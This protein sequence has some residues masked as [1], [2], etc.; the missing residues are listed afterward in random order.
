MNGFYDKIILAV[1]VLALAGSAGYY[2][3][4]MT[5]DGD[6]AAAPTPGGADYETLSAKEISANFKNWPDPTSQDEAGNE[7]YDV[8]TPPK[9]WWDP[10]NQQF[11][12]VPLE[13]PPPPA[14]PFGLRLTSFDQELYRI[15]LEAYFEDLSGEISKAS[16]MFFDNKT[17]TSF[18]GKVGESFPEHDAEILDFTVNKVVNDDGSIRRVPR[19][20]ILDRESGEKIQ[21]TTEERLY[22]PNSYMLNFRTLD[23]YPAETF[24]WEEVGATKSVEDVTYKLLDFDFDK[25]TATVEK[26]FAEDYPA[27][28]KTLSVAD[29]KPAETTVQPESNEE[30][31]SEENFPAGI[32]DIF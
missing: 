16:I 12:F 10:E 30:N 19:V 28:T 24:M 13:D 3:T 9:I 26:T 31:S 22:I 11:I 17:G 29:E 4:S 7:L 2:A 6:N 18:R 15:Q 8:F 27:E 32:D 20:T 14:P 1:G 25:Q 23:P 5:V 21:L